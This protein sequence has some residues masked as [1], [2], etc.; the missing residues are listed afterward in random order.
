MEQKLNDVLENLGLLR[1]KIDPCVYIKRDTEKVILV[2]AVYVDDFI[3]LWKDDALKN[4]IKAALSSKFNMKDLGG[5]K[6]CVGLR[7]TQDNEGNYYIDQELYIREVIEKFNMLESNTVSSPSDPNQKLS[8]LMSPQTSNETESMENVPYQQLVGSLL[9]L[10]QGSRPDIAFAVGD[11]SRFNN[12][13]GKAHWV[14]VKRILR[15]LKGTAHLKIK[16][17]TGRASKLMGYTDADWASDIDN[18]R[19]CTGYVFMLQEGAISWGSRRQPTVALSSTE[20]EY[21]ALS[22]AVQEAIW[23]KQFAQEFGDFTSDQSMVLKCDNQ[24]AIH[25]STNDVYKAR[26]KHIDIRHHFV[27]DAITNWKIQVE[28]VQT[29]QMVADVLTK[30]VPGPKQIFCTNK[31]GLINV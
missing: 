29:D 25:L 17:C 1:S 9:Y 24:G 7:I 31:M 30:G 19:S 14:A 6:Q 23:L 8:K 2:V 27:R 4:E 5:I 11:V 12:C 21:M 26:S 28:Y 13:F 18:R 16:Y 10:V 3:I 22:S 20:A 15:Y